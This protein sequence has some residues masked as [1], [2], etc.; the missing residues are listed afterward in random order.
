L[1]LVY[2]LEVKV[3]GGILRRPCEQVTTLTD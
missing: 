2:T 1:L 3:I